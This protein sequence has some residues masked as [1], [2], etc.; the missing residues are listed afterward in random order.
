MPRLVA[1][2]ALG[3]IAHD[4]VLRTFGAR[5]AAHPF[6]HGAHHTLPGGLMIADS[7]HPSRY[8]VN[9]GVL[10][11]AMFHEVVAGVRERLDRATS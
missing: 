4:A 3:R 1:I 10:T 6:R 8:N 7:Y 9:T 5:L 2:L 11:D